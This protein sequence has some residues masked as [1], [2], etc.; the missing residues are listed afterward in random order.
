[1]GMNQV[2]CFSSISDFKQ[3]HDLIVFS[4]TKNESI[5]LRN[6][7]S[8]HKLSKFMIYSDKLALILKWPM[9]KR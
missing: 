8:L 2:S 4:C 6:L 9:V 1:M 5:R 7:Y 3:W